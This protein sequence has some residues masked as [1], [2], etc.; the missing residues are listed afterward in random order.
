MPKITDSAAWSFETS[1]FFIGFYAEDEHLDPAD[2]FEFQEDID[3]V[4]NGT[5]EW[6]C[7]CVQVYFKHGSDDARDWQLVGADSLGG[8]AYNTVREFYTS[9]RDA[10]PL[11][12]NCSIMRAAR[13]DNVAICH[14]FPSMVSSAIENARNTVAAFKSIRLRTA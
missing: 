7:A 4:R 3:A 1:Q 14:Y 10:N 11:E 2:S 12:R 6:F 13:G 8:C 5:A 9:H